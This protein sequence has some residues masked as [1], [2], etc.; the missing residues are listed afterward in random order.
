M[1]QNNESRAPQNL[2]TQI[3][4]NIRLENVASN[5][6]D[7]IKNIGAREVQILGKTLWTI[8][9]AGERDLADKLRKLSELGFLFIGEDPGGWPPAVVLSKLR[10]KGLLKGNFREVS[11][12]GPDDWFIVER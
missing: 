9:Y 11:W 6:V 4:K 8:E 1:T 7:A 5:I 2:V 10:E 3:L 12:R